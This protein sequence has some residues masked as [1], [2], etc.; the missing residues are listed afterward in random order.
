[1]TYHRTDQGNAEFFVSLTK[2]EL[3]Y[4]HAQKRWLMWRQYWWEPDRVEAVMEWA[5]KALRKRAE[6]AATL[7]DADEYRAEMKHVLA[8]ESLTKLR[9]MVDRA[10]S[11]PPV[12]DAGDAWDEVPHL[13]GVANG[14]VD[15]RRGGLVKPDVK[16]RITKHCG[17]PFDATATA[18]TWDKVLTDIFDEPEM[19]AYFQAAVGYSITG[20]TREQ[21][22]FCLFGEGGNGKSTLTDALTAT[23]DP[24]SYTMPFSTLEFQDRSSVSNDVAALAGRR[25]VVASETQEDVRLNE[26]RIKSLTGD[27]RITARRLYQEYFSFR[28]QAKYWLA[29]NHK[30]RTTDDSHGFW[31][32]MRLI[33][34]LK[35]FDAGSC[36]PHLAVKLQ[37]EKQGILRWAVEGAKTWYEQGLQ[38]PVTV[39]V[40]TAN[41]RVE[42]DPLR[43][44]FEDRIELG[45]NTYM[46]NGDLYEDYIDYCKKMGD[47]FH[48]GRK[49]FSQRLLAKG[50]RQEIREAQRCW[51]GVKIKE[52]V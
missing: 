43:E 8:S 3:R 20:E 51:M 39:T 24:Y 27:A 35:Q 10:R 34:M 23:L 16:Q 6:K 4:D 7:E 50:L 15:L 46:A 32:R 41:Y 2:K 45:A 12:S 44:Y 21:C 25:F 30:P 29:F 22:L 48:L 33:S 26:G 52:P 5:A 47:R 1:M 31:R 36:D 18:P 9:A 17:M 38:T 28:P 40:D 13:L 49:K 11:M 42:N 14:V 19:R 37:A